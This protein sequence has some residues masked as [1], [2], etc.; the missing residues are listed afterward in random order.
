[1]KRFYAEHSRVKLCVRFKKLAKRGAW[2][3]ATTRQR[4]V[5]MPW[6]Q[7]RLNSDCERRFLNAFVKLKQMRMAG[8]GADPDYFYQSFRRKSAN[9]FH[10]KEKCAELNRIEFFA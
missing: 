9:A 10:R 2:N 6:T 4:D 1:M 5:R 7:F 3:I 8:A